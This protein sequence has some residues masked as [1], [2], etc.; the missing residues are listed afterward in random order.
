MI[1]I[2]HGWKFEHFFFF[3]ALAPFLPSRSFS[4][5]WIDNLFLQFT[6]FF[7]FI[8]RICI[9]F[10][11]NFDR[12]ALVFTPSLNSQVYINIGATSGAVS[13]SKSSEPSLQTSEPHQSEMHQSE[14]GC[15]SILTLIVFFLHSPVFTFYSNSQFRTSEDQVLINMLWSV[16]LGISSFVLKN[17]PTDWIRR[18]KRYKK[19]W[20]THVEKYRK[21]TAY[22]HA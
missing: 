10:Y 6:F 18:N 20:K 5:Y 15:I 13:Y 8:D 17:L 7:Y 16:E 11:V 2:F 21:N 9:L 22:K 4:N 1:K 3:F 12:L 14:T 19:F